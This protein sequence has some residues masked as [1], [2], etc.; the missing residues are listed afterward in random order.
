M[1]EIFWKRGTMQTPIQH[2]RRRSRPSSAGVAG[3]PPSSSSSSLSPPMKKTKPQPP[4][5][6]SAEKNGLH[7]D[8]AAAAA[9]AAAVVRPAEEE[10][11]MLVDAEAE[12]A[13]AATTGVA[14]NLFRKKATPPQPSAKK[15]L[16]IK[17]TKGQPKLPTNF[18]DD[19]WA[20]LKAAISAIFLKQ[21]LSCDTEKLYQA[22]GDLCLYKMGQIFMNA[23]RKNVKAHISK[24]IIIG[25][26][27]S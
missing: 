9:A 7:V 1:T 18:E 26:T 15:Q 3:T 13:A 19:T 10:E 21:P 2:R 6:S 20:K 16:R 23:C 8:P 12:P 5:S 11:A 4:P 17:I 27:K 24:T 14:A 25:W 22:V